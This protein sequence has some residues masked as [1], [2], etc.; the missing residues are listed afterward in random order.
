M[1]GAKAELDLADVMSRRLFVTGSTL[2]SRSVEQKALIAESLLA[3]VWPE[4]SSGHVQPVVFATYPFGGAAIA[5]QTMEASTH[6]GKILL[7]P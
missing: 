3:N 4:I 5:H 7:L 2:R 6:I 1:E